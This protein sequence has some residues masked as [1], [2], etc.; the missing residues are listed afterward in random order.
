MKVLFDQN[1]PRNLADFLTAHEVTRSIELGW[2]RLKNGELLKAAEEVDFEI[3]ATCD[4]NLAYQQNLRNR[5]LAIVVLPA[6]SIKRKCRGGW[7]RGIEA[8]RSSRRLRS[9]LLVRVDWL[10]SV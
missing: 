1:V 5:K 7:L 4:R 8:R 6:A 10:S 2:D 3:L 9:Q